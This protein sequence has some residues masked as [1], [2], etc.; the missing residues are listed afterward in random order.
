MTTGACHHTWLVLF[1]VE[2][3]FHH[4]GQAELELLTSGDLPTSASQSV[5]ITGVS[6][7]ARPVFSFLLLRVSL[8]IQLSDSVPTASTLSQRVSA[9][10]SGNRLDPVTN[11]FS[12]RG[13]TTGRAV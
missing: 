5:G 3:G 9:P 1:L 13:T 10:R 7:R 2:T 11:T 6:H 8:L 4:V 12:A